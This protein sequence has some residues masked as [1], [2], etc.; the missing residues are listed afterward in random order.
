[1]FSNYGLFKSRDWLNPGGQLNNE[2]LMLIVE[3]N[4]RDL[5]RKE[6][7]PILLWQIPKIIK[8]LIIEMYSPSP[9]AIT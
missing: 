9:D 4:K 7:Y 3:H 8:N 5:M 6:K 1:M 2:T